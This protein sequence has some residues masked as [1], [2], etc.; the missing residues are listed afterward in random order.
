[1]S[2]IV[3]TAVLGACIVVLANI[4]SSAAD[5]KANETGD[6]FQTMKPASSCVIMDGDFE[7][8]LEGNKPKRTSIKK[9]LSDLAKKIKQTQES[10]KQQLGAEFSYRTAFLNYKYFNHRKANGIALDLIDRAKIKPVDREIFVNLC[11]Y[12]PLIKFY[13]L[14]ATAG[15]MDPRIPAVT[16]AAES[17]FRADEKSG[18]KEGGMDV[19][20]AQINS[21]YGESFQE[22]Y[23]NN[24]YWIDGRDFE[25]IP[26]NILLG[27]LIIAD[28][29]KAAKVTSFDKSKPIDLLRAYDGYVMGAVRKLSS[30][31][32]HHLNF[33]TCTRFVK[34]L[35]YV[36]A[37]AKEGRLIDV[38][39][40]KETMSTMEQALTRMPSMHAKYLLECLSQGVEPNLEGYPNLKL[41]KN[42]LCTKYYIDYSE[43]G[44]CQESDAEIIAMKRMNWIKRNIDGREIDIYNYYIF[45]NGILVTVEG[46]RMYFEVLDK[47]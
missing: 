22:L 11:K 10:C 45:K 43:G 21:N 14:N 32:A 7:K 34:L 36:D 18:N 3:K 47:E 19:G 33:A 6:R 31:W 38:K 8:L 13:S 29:C 16:I 12:W 46:C 35:P 40:M 41:V 4:P 30:V 20:L 17:R 24:V 23:G 39:A 2:K 9:S 1:M 15:P 42:D 25:C 5:K 28:R 44:R 26:N 37:A 27:V